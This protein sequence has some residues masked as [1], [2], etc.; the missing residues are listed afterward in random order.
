M[1]NERQMTITEIAESADI[2]TSLIR[3]WIREGRLKAT[4]FGKTWVIAESD[5]KAFDATRDKRTWSSKKAT[6]KAKK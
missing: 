4:L 1:S 2:T 5:W 3:R 6:S